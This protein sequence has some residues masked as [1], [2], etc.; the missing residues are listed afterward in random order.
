MEEA[1]LLLQVHHTLQ[2]LC[3]AVSNNPTTVPG[4]EGKRS[5]REGIRWKVLTECQEYQSED[6]RCRGYVRRKT[7]KGRNILI[8]DKLY[9]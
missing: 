9:S 8:C 2:S 5:L 7:P 4:A 6:N 1:T 3:C